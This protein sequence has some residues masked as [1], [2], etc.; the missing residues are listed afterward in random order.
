MARPKISF[1]TGRKLRRHPQYLIYWPGASIKRGGF[2]HPED[3]DAL[4]RACAEARID[5][6]PELAEIIQENRAGYSIS[7]P[8]AQGIRA[9]LRALGNLADEETAQAVRVL[10]DW[11]DAQLCGAAARIWRRDHPAPDTPIPADL[12][13]PSS[14]PPERIR[15]TARTALETMPRKDGRRPQ[16]NRDYWFGV[17]LVRYWSHATGKRPTV[18]APTDTAKASVFLTWAA[19]MFKRAGRRIHTS[20]LAKTLQRAKRL[21]QGHG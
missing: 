7:R 14:W 13:K 15:Q 12:F 3:A 1:R 9:T 2:A 18:T 5:Y 8:P 19:A 16:W 17:A 10:D 20:D 6:M 21:G 11:T 4:R